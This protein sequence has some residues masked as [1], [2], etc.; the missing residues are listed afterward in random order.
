MSARRH[1]FRHRLPQPPSLCRRMLLVLLDTAAVLFRVTWDP[2]C[3]QP[4]IQHY[5]RFA[6]V[7][8]PSVLRKLSDRFRCSGTSH[9][10][11]SRTGSGIMLLCF[12]R[13]RHHRRRNVVVVG[14]HE[15]PEDKTSATAAGTHPADALQPDASGLAS[16]PKYSP[17]P[18]TLRS[19]QSS[20]TSTNTLGAS[21]K[22]Q[23]AL[24]LLHTSLLAPRRRKN[25]DFFRC[26]FFHPKKN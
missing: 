11:T 14:H 9:H 6:V 8:I 20:S 7:V 26:A 23:Q 3:C 18:K 24:F 17:A 13:R 2:H 19:N 10:D 12:H 5:S 1:C 25:V 4:M 21:C 16:S 15:I 22:L